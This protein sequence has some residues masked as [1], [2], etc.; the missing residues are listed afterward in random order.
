MRLTNVLM[1]V[2]CFDRLLP[3]IGFSKRGSFDDLGVP[4]N[5]EVTTNHNQVRVAMFESRYPKVVAAML[6]ERGMASGAPMQ[7][8]CNHRQLKLSVFQR[9]HMDDKGDSHPPLLQS[10]I[11]PT[12]EQ[13]FSTT[14]YMTLTLCSVKERKEGDAETLLSQMK[15]HFE[16]QNENK[17]CRK[18]FARLHSNMVDTG[19]AKGAEF[20]RLCAI[21]GLL[22]GKDESWNE[23]VVPL[24]DLIAF[25]KQVTSNPPDVD[26]ASNTGL[27]HWMEHYTL[28]RVYDIDPDVPAEVNFDI[29][30]QIIRSLVS[31]RVNFIEGQ[32]R[33]D[34]IAFGGIGNYFPADVVEAKKL[35]KRRCRIERAMARLKLSTK[36]TS[37]NQVYERQIFQLAVHSAEQWTEQCAA[38]CNFGCNIDQS[39]NTVVQTTVASTTLESFDEFE[40]NGLPSFV[41]MEPTW[42]WSLGHDDFKAQMDANLSAVATA[43]IG[44]IVKKKRTELFLKSWS[45]ANPDKTVKAI[46]D[47]F[48]SQK[49]KIKSN[50]TFTGI[51]SNHIP[52]LMAMKYLCMT[53]EG[54]MVFCSFLSQQ[55]PQIP[56]IDI[57]GPDCSSYFFTP[58][59]V[60]Y[61]MIRCAFDCHK[62]IM[63]V[64]TEEAW[65][66]HYVRHVANGD[67]T[68]RRCMKNNN[69]DLSQN[70]V[71]HQ[72][73][74]KRS[75]DYHNATTLGGQTLGK[76]L[77][78]ANFVIMEQLMF[79]IF[80]TV[81]KVGPNPAMVYPYFYTF[82]E[83][84]QESFI[85]NEK[86]PNDKFRMYHL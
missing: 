47:F 63:G 37:G 10:L 41:D 49:V 21:F 61:N 67:D 74:R 39:K 2:P 50:M 22:W 80:S 33:A 84:S 20:R 3:D 72:T 81:L 68:V 85:K 57:K 75:E 83:L 43:H 27:Q 52:F 48:R 56:Q 34:A 25:F 15:Y 86:F 4:A 53:P 7:A 24:A 13:W 30:C 18:L 29:L 6:K 23:K 54:R 36:T 42:F 9:S 64:V 71:C 79:D 32:H 60:L 11:C 76:F 35:D 78:R 8:R 46:E 82:K 44:Y 26:L 55:P 40:T 14:N 1:L 28:D 69:W 31:I 73:I 17:T 51:G 38:F 16:V 66:V 19:P 77:S 59:F 12:S 45:P 70:N 62:H 5:I 65:L 58:K